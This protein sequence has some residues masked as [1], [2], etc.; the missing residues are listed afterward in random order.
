MPKFQ[1]LLQAVDCVVLVDNTELGTDWLDELCSRYIDDIASGVFRCFQPKQN[2][3][4]AAAQNLALDFVFCHYSNQDKVI[5]FDQDSEIPPHLP[6][7]LARA[8]ERLSV[9]TPIAAIG[10]SFT[11]EH[12]GF[13]YPQVNWSKRGAF[14]RFMPD[15]TQDHQPVCSLISSGMLTTIDVLKDIGGYDERLFIDYVDT[16]WCLKA[17]SK[18]YTLYVI[19]SIQMQHAIGAKSIRVFGRYLSVHSPTRRYYMLRNSLFMSRKPYVSG[20]LAMSFVFRTLVHH[21]IL[22]VMVPGRRKQISAFVKGMI[23]GVVN[24]K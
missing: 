15:L 9:H 24:A 6:A 16:D 7:S 11:D 18:G 21:M 14:Q 20:W 1:V 12:K 8:F 3:G 4:I 13:V 19:P 10:P 17:Q 23:D 2:L 5:F 22:I